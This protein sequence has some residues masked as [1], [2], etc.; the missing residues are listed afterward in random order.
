MNDIIKCYG[1]RNLPDLED[2]DPLFLCVLASTQTAKIPGITGA[3]ATTELTDYTPAADVELIVHGKPLCLPDIPQ[4]VVGGT[5]AP[6]PA[7]ITKAALE[8][9]D[10]PFIVVDAGA[11]VKPDLPFVN[12]N[13]KSG[14]NITEGRAVS[15]PENI[16]KKGK[17]LGETLSKLTDHLFIGESTPAGTTTALGVLTAMGYDG[18]RKVSGSMPFNPHELK[19]M[20][21]SKGLEAAG[22]K[23]GDLANDPWKAVGTVGDPMIPAVAGIAAGSNVP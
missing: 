23:A 11:A 12:I 10:I 3:G 20:T 18:N 8:L 1:R 6:T 13:Q 17:I 5:A 9:A 7:V 15:N 2:K 19:Q 22:Y 16:F 21:V 4:T 14:G